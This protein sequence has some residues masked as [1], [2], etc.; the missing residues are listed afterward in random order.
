MIDGKYE[1]VD[2][3]VWKCNALEPLLQNCNRWANKRTHWSSCG[4]A[5]LS[6]ITGL[7]PGRVEKLLP[8]RRKDWTDNAA[9][10]LLRKRGFSVRQLSKLGV[11]NLSPQG[12]SFESMP[13]DLDHVL[14]C[15]CLCCYHEASWF[16]VHQGVIFHCFEAQ[17]LHPLFFV[18]KPSQSVWLV[19]HRK[20]A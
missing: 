5:A 19:K 2:W 12:T 4:S 16:I 10:G 6:V 15:N 18:N 7:N 17:M 11:T 1:T 20:W 9:I 3:E 13:I 14:L 8:M